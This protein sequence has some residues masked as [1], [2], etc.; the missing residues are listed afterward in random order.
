MAEQIWQPFF[1]VSVS[2]AWASSDL[3]L[4]LQG[5]N[6]ANVREPPGKNWE[7]IIPARSDATWADQIGKETLPNKGLH[8]GP[9]TL[10]VTLGHT[11]SSH[12][13]QLKLP[14]YA[15]FRGQKRS[16]FLIFLWCHFNPETHFR[17]ER[18]SHS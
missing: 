7:Q 12:H 6:L 17:L 4:S 16:C 11:F 2:L 18:E 10:L 13:T 5:K 1:V 15:G 8:L 3:L 9:V 14:K